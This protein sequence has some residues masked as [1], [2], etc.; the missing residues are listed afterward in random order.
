MAR[1][2]PISLGLPRLS[3]HDIQALSNISD[4]MQKVRMRKTVNHPDLFPKSVLD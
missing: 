1:Q 2:H 4:E 3:L